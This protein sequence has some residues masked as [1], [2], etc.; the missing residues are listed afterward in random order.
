MRRSLEKEVGIPTLL[1]MRE[2]GKS[3]AEIAAHFDVHRT[4]VNNLI[5]PQP[6]GMR[7]RVPNGTVAVSPAPV[8]SFTERLATVRP[9]PEPEPE[10]TDGFKVLSGKFKAESAHARYV[11]DALEH[12]TTIAFKRQ[13]IWEMSAD[14]ID[15][16]IEELT[17]IKKLML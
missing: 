16:F 7:K 4:T 2:E 3:N 14:E 5:G 12:K 10:W 8:M 9:A 1:H 17:Q 11:V 6:K 13:D 15:D